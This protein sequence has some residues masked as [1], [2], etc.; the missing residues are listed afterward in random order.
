MLLVSFGK[1]WDDEAFISDNRLMTKEE[2]DKIQI[3]AIK[4]FSEIG[5]YHFSFGS[6]QEIVFRSLND[7]FD[8]FVVYELSD[9]EKSVFMKYKNAIE[10]KL[11]P[12]IWDLVE[13]EN[14]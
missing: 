11:F 9:E 6:N 3:G 7:F 8:S 5:Y 12:D 10:G 4:W 13:C 2:W 1:W 14:E